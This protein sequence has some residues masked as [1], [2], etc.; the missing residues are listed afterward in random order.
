MEPHEE[1]RIRQRGLIVLVGF[2]AFGAVIAGLTVVM[3]LAPG[4]WADAVWRLKPSAQSDFRALGAGAVALML[5]V[6]LACAGAAVGLWR[7]R[8]WG[9]WLAVGVLATNLV[10]DL[11]NALLRHDWRTLIGIPVGGAMLLYLG[12]SHVRDRYLAAG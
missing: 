1:P 8:R 10:G 5:A 9:Y 2:F 4:S 6:T 11:T 12:R 7:G 3:L